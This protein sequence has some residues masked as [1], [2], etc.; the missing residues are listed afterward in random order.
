MQIKE[1]YCF[2]NNWLWILIS[3]NNQNYWLRF[4]QITNLK[5]IDNR[6]KERDQKTIDNLKR[7]NIKIINNTP[8]GELVAKH[9]RKEKW[10]QYLPAPNCPS[11]SLDPTIVKHIEN[12]LNIL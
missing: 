5:T 6:L 10:T 2:S 11:Y 3:E 7:L 9:L 8:H 4:D 1:I 12:P